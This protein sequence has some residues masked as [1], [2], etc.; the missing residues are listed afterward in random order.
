MKLNKNEYLKFSNIIFSPSINQNCLGFPQKLYLAIYCR[1]FISLVQH[2]KVM[3]FITASSQQS[4]V[5]RLFCLFL[6]Y[7]KNEIIFKQNIIQK[8]IRLY[9]KVNFFFPLYILHRLKISYIDNQ[10][11]LLI[12]NSYGFLKVYLSKFHPN[13]IIT[14]WVT[15]VILTLLFLKTMV[16]K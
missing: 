13:P 16:S 1:I 11:A 2:M 10:T 3:V 14:A 15:V 12:K 9:P 6:N 8:F 4:K 7:F 5:I